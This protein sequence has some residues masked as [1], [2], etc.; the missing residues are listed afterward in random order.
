MQVKEIQ[1]KFKSPSN[2]K[3]SQRRRQSK[4]F[5]QK[6]DTHRQKPIILMQRYDEKEDEE[7]Q[8]TIKGTQ[9]QIQQESER[10]KEQK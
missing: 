4:S 8:I 6:I 7:Q 1:E 5:K 3:S 9:L 10:Q 2:Q